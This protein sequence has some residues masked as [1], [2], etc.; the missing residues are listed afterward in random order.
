[1][2]QLRI[3]LNCYPTTDLTGEHE[4][5]FNVRGDNEAYFD[6]LRFLDDNNRVISPSDVL[7]EE[8][9]DQLSYTFENGPEGWTFGKRGDERASEGTGSWSGQHDG[10]LRLHV[11]GA[12]E[13]IM[14]WKEVGPLSAGTTI[15]ANYTPSRFE[16]AA[17]T[18]RLSAV[19]PGEG[20]VVSDRDSDNGENPEQDGNLQIEIPRDLPAEAQL[21]FKLVIWPGETTVY[22]QDVQSDSAAQ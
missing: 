4:L 21:E 15:T 12:P 22:I 10:S 1:M 17:A 8:S 16:Y 11:D 20:T 9:P 2:S 13:A 7:V 5:V 6:N 14:A 19:I 3:R 18:L